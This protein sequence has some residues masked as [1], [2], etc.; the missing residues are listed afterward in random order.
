MRTE[1][2]LVTVLMAT[3]NGA[4]HIS[5]QIDSILAQTYSNIELV[6]ADDSSMDET[7]PILRS[8]KQKHPNIKLYI[9]QIRLGF[10]KNFEQLLQKADGK[11]FALSDQDDI[12]DHDKISIMMQAL[13]EKEKKRPDAP[14]M[15]HSDLKVIDEVGALI[16]PSYSLHRDYHFSNH[17]NIP[18][19]LS[20][21]GVMGNTILLNNHLRQLILPFDPDVMHHDYWIALI[22]EIFGF[23]ISLKETLV[24]YRIHTHNTSNKMH[25]ISNQHQKNKKNILPYQDN[26]RYKVLRGILQRF[27]IEKDD[28]RPIIIFLKY[29]REQKNWLKYYRPLY[30]EGFIKNSIRTHSKLLGRF[31][32]AS[33]KRK[34]ALKSS[35]QS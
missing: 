19:M 18:M 4:R 33:L 28:K 26:N 20:K 13:I 31:T 34:Q 5:E 8:Y 23:R 16:F 22:N 9:N 14:I 12:W 29:L 15:I 2:P 10:V 30:K 11:Y 6:I 7:V 1:L 25:L 24:S 35:I 21:G 3:Y 27:P 17:K 32:L